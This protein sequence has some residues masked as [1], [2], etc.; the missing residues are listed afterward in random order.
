MNLLK[1]L[2]KNEL[3][4][5]KDAGVNILDKEYS[6]EELR[7]CESKVEEFIMNHSSK[8]GELN[9]YNV[10]YSDIL[11]NLIKYQQ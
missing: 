11:N 2:S 9:K 3:K 7:E 8:N 6:K 4:L 10:Q 5:L 1:D